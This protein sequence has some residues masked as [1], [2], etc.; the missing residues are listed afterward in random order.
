[1]CGANVRADPATA[2]TSKADEPIDRYRRHGAGQKNAKHDLTSK[3]D[4]PA[5]LA[6][7]IAELADQFGAQKIHRRGPQCSRTEQSLSI[8]IIGGWRLR[9]CPL[10]STGESRSR[11][12]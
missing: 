6:K 9:A 11:R 7:R 1:M 10:V 3:F 12:P 2:Q 5:R 8:S 4:P